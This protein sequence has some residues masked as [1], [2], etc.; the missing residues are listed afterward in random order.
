MYGPRQDPKSP[1]SG[2]IS[3][4]VDFLS[5][6]KIPSIYGDGE[7]TRDFIYVKDVVNANIRSMEAIIEGSYVFNVGSGQSVSINQLFE[8]LQ[9]LLKTS[10]KPKQL[11]LREGD[12]RHSCAD[13]TR[14]R[15]EF[16]WQYE[17]EIKSGL[18]KDIANNSGD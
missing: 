2:V 4:F 14:I 7:Q 16:G 11:P 1:Y 3:I 17:W 5:N 6:G 12:I 9:H 10:I 13:V 18:E 8:L 15:E